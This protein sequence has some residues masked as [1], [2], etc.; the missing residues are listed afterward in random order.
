L[1]GTVLAG[2]SWLVWRILLIAAMGEA[3]TDDER[4]VFKAFTGRDKEPGER[5]FILLVIAGRRAG[6][7]RASAVLIAY[8]AVF[9]KHGAK[10][11]PGE[12]AVILCLAQNRQQAGVVF[13]YVRGAFASV[14]LLADLVANETKE[15]LELTNGVVIDVRAASYRGLRGI[16]AIAVIADEACFW[17]NEDSG[18]A[19]SDTEIL[20]A[21]LPMLATTGGP[22]VIISSPYSKRGEAYLIWSKNFGPLGDP[23]ILVAQGASR[24]FNESLPQRIVDAAMERDSAAAS[25][26]YL[27]L[28]R[29]DIS[30]FI[31]RETI[32]ARVSRGVTGRG[33]LPQ[34]EYVAAVDPSGGSGADS[35]TMAICHLEE[36]IAVLDCVLERR[37]PLSPEAVT[38]EFCKTLSEY[39]ITSV[40]GDR[41][42]G[43]WPSER[44]AVNG[45]C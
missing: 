29:N 37:P 28:W 6:K 26:E 41:Y 1:L 5:C 20:A 44:F 16:T 34:F 11:A 7:S 32:V 24:D 10:L 21:V 13:G 2:P 25:S 23:K 12:K 17:H 8:L 33:P 39:A 43:L 38:E 45:V 31:D 27:G 15:S 9:W 40:V 18:S 30:A 3:L 35:F 14:E 42:A 19:N 22:L 36:G 4:V